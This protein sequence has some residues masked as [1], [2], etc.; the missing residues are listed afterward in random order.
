M[1]DT[2]IYLITFKDENTQKIMV[3]HGIGNNTLKNICL[4]PEELRFFR[5]KQ[6]DAG[7]YI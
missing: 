3:S 2:K 7:Y 5:P 6:D 1:N 4:P